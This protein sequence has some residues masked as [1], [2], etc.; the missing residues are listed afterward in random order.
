[1][2]NSKL[3]WRWAVK[4]RS[5]SNSRAISEVRKQEIVSLL[6]DRLRLSAA[7]T[8]TKLTGCR[9]ANENC[10]GSVTA[11]F[12]RLLSSIKCFAAAGAFVSFRRSP[13]YVG[14]A[15]EAVREAVVEIYMQQ[16]RLGWDIGRGVWQ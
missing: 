12:V 8:D 4:C 7:V 13:T 11:N 16:Y 5:N 6:G 10:V 15:P 3:V 14:F 1:M 2:K 9:E